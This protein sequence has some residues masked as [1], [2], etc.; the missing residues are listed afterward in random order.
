MGDTTVALRLTD[1]VARD[2]PAPEKG[3]RITYDFRPPWF[4]A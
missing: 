3:Y 4:W 2:T 1:K